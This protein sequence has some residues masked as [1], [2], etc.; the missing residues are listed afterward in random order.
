M[1]ACDGA[2]CAYQLDRIEPSDTPSA[3]RRA[4]IRCAYCADE[5][6]KLTMRT[7]EEIDAE[8]AASS[9]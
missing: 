1:P 4:Y 9:A 3:A 6:G 8:I 2:S 5:I 7:D